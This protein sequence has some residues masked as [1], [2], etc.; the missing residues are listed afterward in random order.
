MF[1]HF[2]SKIL[3]AIDIQY[4][5]IYIAVLSLNGKEGNVDHKNSEEKSGASLEPLPVAVRCAAPTY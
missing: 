3:L 4:I 1:S 2:A 5:R